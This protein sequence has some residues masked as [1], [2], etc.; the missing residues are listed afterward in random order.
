[1]DPAAGAVGEVAF[2][3]ESG[4]HADAVSLAERILK[5]HPDSPA[6]RRAAA[7]ARTAAGVSTTRG[8]GL[9]AMDLESLDEE[10]QSLHAV[11]GARPELPPIED[12]EHSLDFENFSIPRAPEAEIIHAPSARSVAPPPP[13]LPRPATAQASRGGAPAAITSDGS[14][15][16]L[17]TQA[18]AELGAGRAADA[19]ATAS[20]AQVMLP[21][22]PRAQA[23]IDRARTLIDQRA[24]EVEDLLYEAQRCLE[25]REWSGAK[26]FLD[27]V[28]ARQPDH[29]EA[30]SLVAEVDGLLQAEEK[31]PAPAGTEAMDSIPLAGAPPVPGAGAADSSPP[32]PGTEAIPLAQTPA[33]P[34]KE[35][36]HAEE[37][38]RKQSRSSSSRS[39]RSSRKGMPGAVKGLIVVGVLLVL[40][41][42]GF[43]GYRQYNRSR[44]IAARAAKAGAPEGAPKGRKAKQEGAPSPAAAVDGTT[45]A[46]PAAAAPA[47]KPDPAALVV[48]GKKAVAAE[49]W[50]DAVTALQAAI[51]ADPASLEA[52]DLLKKAQAGKLEAERVAHDLA[53]AKR[54]FASGMYAD[55]LRVLYRL[56]DSMQKGQVERAKRNAWFNFAITDLQSGDCKNALTHFDEALSLDPK[57]ARAVKE[58]QFASSWI[59][60]EKDP[61]FF[62]YAAAIP[63]RGYDE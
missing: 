56:P 53:Q 26:G 24:R 33:A 36:A 30:R 57:D 40:A 5:Q 27:E 11:D 16:G 61:A 60:R 22:D 34:P 4:R 43:L 13:A 39:G 12:I 17:L 7:D 55:T 2:L 48:E 47:A 31:G 35:R 25:R 28:L 8:P 3:I 21:D 63:I 37:R 45:N 15:E 51:A 19:V 50:E 23:V 54:S 62:A 20:R 49:Q 46:P 38:E 52:S 9:D 44:I 1:V 6:A 41:V 14:F 18:E 42:G 59:D 32:I 29:A 10:V 58:K